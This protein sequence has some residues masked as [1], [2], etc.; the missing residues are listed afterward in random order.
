MAKTK[1]NTVTDIKIADLTL[2]ELKSKA[3]EL[4]KKIAR[5]RLEL[6]AGKAKNIREG[7]ITRK[8]LARVLSALSNK[9]E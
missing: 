1:K 7:Y 3:G 2:P 4:R 8:Q 5:L 6:R 9:L